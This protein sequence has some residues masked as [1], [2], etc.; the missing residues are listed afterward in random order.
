MFPV[1]TPSQHSVR[2]SHL[3]APKL[4]TSCSTVGF[5]CVCVCVYV[6]LGVGWNAT[7]LVSGRSQKVVALGLSCLL[8]IVETLSKLII[9]AATYHLICSQSSMSSYTLI[10]KWQVHNVAYIMSDEM[11]SC[12]SGVSA[13]HVNFLMMVVATTEICQN[14]DWSVE[15]FTI[16]KCMM[17]MF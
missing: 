12:D 1:L 10:M 7:L 14:M 17:Q 15:N 9:P 5:V 11:S 13:Y 8:V 6:Q 16:I 4:M 2:A 3:V